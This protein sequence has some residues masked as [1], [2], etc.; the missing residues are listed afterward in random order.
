MMRSIPTALT[1]L[2]IAL[3]SA[4]TWLVY[5]TNTLQGAAVLMFH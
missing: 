2:Q 4:A 3:A 1:T 5:E